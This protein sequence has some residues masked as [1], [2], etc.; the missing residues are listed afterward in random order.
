MRLG[1]RR[2]KKTLEVMVRKRVQQRKKS[3]MNLLWKEL[4]KREGGKRSKNVSA[5]KSKPRIVAENV[6]TKEEKP[7]QLNCTKAN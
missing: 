1:K 5:S 4:K 3:K 6:K 2:R 7:K